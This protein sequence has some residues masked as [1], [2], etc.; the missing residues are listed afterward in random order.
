[1][2]ISCIKRRNKFYVQKINSRF[3]SIQKHPQFKPTIQISIFS[4]HLS[5]GLL[6][7]LLNNFSMIHFQ[8]TAGRFLFYLRCFKHSLFHD[9]Q[10][11]LKLQFD[12]M[13]SFFNLFT[14]IVRKLQLLKDSRLSLN[15]TLS[16]IVYFLQLLGHFKFEVSPPISNTPR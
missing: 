2:H 1:M 7:K 10:L 13:G 4:L 8:S 14:I 12:T 9:T 16:T 6:L 11:P 15:L 5:T 3:F